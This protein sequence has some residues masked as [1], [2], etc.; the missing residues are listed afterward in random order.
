MSINF[1]NFNSVVSLFNKQ[2]KEL[3]DSPYLWRK[4]EGKFLSLSWLEVQKKVNA[5]KGLNK[6]WDFKRG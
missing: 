2:C 5:S 4:V 6:S 1:E 3:K